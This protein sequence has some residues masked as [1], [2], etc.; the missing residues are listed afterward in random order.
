MAVQYC[1]YDIKG[2]LAVTGVSS[3]TGNATFA[4]GLAVNN[5]GSSRFSIT[6][7]VKV[8]GA[9]D[10]AIPAGRKFYLDGQSNTYLTES[11]ADNLKFFTGG[12]V[13]LLLNSSQN[14]IFANDIT[15]SGGDIVSNGNTVVS[16]SANANTLRL[17]DALLTSAVLNIK[18][19]TNG[20]DR[21]TI[22]SS[23][24]ATFAGN[25]SALVVTARDNLFVDAGQLYIG[26]DN[27]S[28]DN[29][30]RQVVNTGAGTFTL[31]KRISGTFTN[32]LSFDNSNN[33]TFAGHVFVEDGSKFF[34]A[35]AIAASSEDGNYVASFGKS[36]SGSAKF[37]GNIT[38]GGGTSTF[39][40]LVS[41]ITPTSG[42]NFA[43]KS[44]VDGLTP[45]SG[46]FLPLVGGTMSGA[47]NMG[48]NDIDGI[49]ELKFSSG[50]KLGDAGGTSYVSL[51]YADSGDGGILVI[52]NQGQHQ[53]YLYGDGGATSSFGLLDGTGSWAVRCL[54]DQYVELRY[55]NAIKLRTATGGINVTGAGNF[56]GNIVANDGVSGKITISP[57]N[58]Q[59]N[60]H[61]I[62]GASGGANIEMYTNGNAYYD[63]VSHNFRDSDA[64]PTYFNITAS[65]VN[66]FVSLAMNNYKI[67]TLA[68][69]TNAAD[70][71]N[72]AYVDAQI[73]TIPSGLNFQGNW[74]ASTNSP[75]LA[76]GTGTPGFYYNVSV[77][78]STNLDGETDWQVGD[79]AVFVENG[80]NDFWEKIDNTSA[81]TG[82]GAN[83]QVSLWGGTN[84]LEG[85]TALTFT[86]GDLYVTGD[87][88][89]S[90]WYSAYQDTITAFSDSGSSTI[91]L[92]LTQRDGGTLT[93]S[94]S[95][96]QGTVTGTGSVNVIPLW[97]G[98]GSLSTSYLQQNTSLANDILMPQYIRHT[99]DT[100]T[101]IGFP[102]GDRVILH[103]GGNSNVELVSNGVTL[104]NNGSTKLE[105]SSTGVS[106]TGEGVFTNTSSGAETDTI[107]LRN[108][109]T[110]QNTATALKFFP[111]TSTTRF[112]SIV[113]KNVTG[114]N[115]ISLSFLT[116]AGNTPA[117]ALTLDASQNAT[118]AGSV[119]VGGNAAS[120][121]YMV[122]ITP[123][124]GN[125]IRST[126]G[127]SV[128]GS[129]QSNNS[130]V[131]LG[132]IS[133][134]T[135]KIITNDTTAITV[136]N[137]QG[138]TFAGTIDSGAVTST[139]I[140]KSNTA[141]AQFKLT[142][143]HGRETVLG[144]GGGNFHI[145]PDHGSGVGISYGNTTYPGL[146][147]LYNNTTAK[148]TLDATAGNATFTGN[149]AVGNTSAAEIYLNRSSANY[150]NA[151][152][153]AGYLVFRTGGT[154]TALTLDASQDA[155]F[156][157][158]VNVGTFSDSGTSAINIRAGGEH[159]TKLGLFESNLNHGF[160][161]NY[162]G[163]LNQFLIK[164]HDNSAAGSTVLS[165][166]RVNN[167]AVFA[168]DI[169]VQGGDI[170]LGGTGRIQG[171]DTVSD[172]TDAANKAY[173]DAHV[174]PAGTYLPLAGG[175]M[176]DTNKIKFYNASQYI[177]ANSTNDLTIASGDDI[178][179][180]SNFSRFY[181]SGL[182]FARLS[183]SNDSWIANGTNSKLGVNKSS[184]INYNL[185]V[186]GT[187]RTTGAATIEG[188]I[189]ANGTIQTLAS[190]A[191]LTISG[192]SSGNVY[193][194]NT[195]GEHRWRANGSSVN[196]ITLSSSLLTVN[197]PAT[198][199]G[200][201]TTNLSSEGT[202]FT[203]GSGG[204]R[205]LSITS[206]TNSSAHALHTFNIASTNGKY[207]F[208]VNGTTEL[209]LD[210]SSA[211]FAGDIIF[212]NNNQALK[213]EGSDNLLVKVKAGNTVM[214]FDGGNIKTVANQN[215]EFDAGL[216]D[217][218]GSTG[219]AGQLLSSTGTTV[220]W[221][222]APSGGGANGTTAE[223]TGSN[224]NYFSKL[225]TFTIS[226]S[227]SFADL[228]AAFTII[229]EETSNSAYAEISVMMRKG[230]SSATSLDAINIAVLN[231]V[232]NGDIESQISSDNFYL[233]YTSGATM[234]VDLYMKKNA[235]FG[236]FDIIETASNFDDW[237]TTYYTNS[238]W[239]SALPSSTYT[240]QTKVTSGTF[241]TGAG[242]CRQETPFFGPQPTSPYP[243]WFPLPPNG[244]SNTV[245]KTSLQPTNFSLWQFQ[246]PV[247][248]VFQ[249][250][251]ISNISRSF[252]NM[253]VRIFDQGNGS[254]YPGTEVFTSATFSA[255][256]HVMAAVPINLIMDAGTVYA[257]SIDINSN[258]SP[259]DY[260]ITNLFAT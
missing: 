103:A 49:D 127:T 250:V 85:T 45:G 12:S 158:D 174:S 201:I 13:A 214:T 161:L 136:S 124:A 40:G 112:A 101:L 202:Y 224:A 143:T 160:S 71:A 62:L 173:V 135:F 11:S 244:P 184:G 83:N 134:N 235:T 199:T 59:S 190:N 129:Y 260:R 153:A 20:A 207:E 108:S 170:T 26:A 9:T 172:G 77:A 18:L 242:F 138:A 54:E 164:R 35:N 121:G 229:G 114:N 211:T 179:Y 67:T 23:G 90:N 168:G 175:T 195:A 234:A 162:D 243:N 48:D 2:T 105:T 253:R 239:I 10:F 192:D 203:G 156:A 68:T 84:T 151:S 241:I 43:T 221:I 237:V 93:T 91:T 193:Y 17:G 254:T 148:I 38:V 57:D 218:N 79:W 96:P 74:N 31:Q 152:N 140:I 104:R 99:G 7:D 111:T 169:S 46:V 106:V 92:T 42:A 22:N 194:N 137:S 185:D 213:V 223:G 144:Q 44:Y 251:S 6:G 139:G 30:F 163:G 238:A 47:I 119:G 187:F 257:M 206:G 183:G 98:T 149:L 165:L 113:A 245:A 186:E 167:G 116:A 27:G 72:K 226:S 142:S 51:T 166:N 210:S 94:F 131:Y 32:V 191:N 240:I 220:D 117:V 28:T 246:M 55:D 125:I 61:L 110:A 3:F 16:N 63:A 14:A 177:H 33:A 69:P 76:S 231:N 247:D 208:D 88:N 115:S 19:R 25:T 58:I 81:L 107:S 56:T 65:Q 259:N 205:Q 39:A 78:G 255:A 212:E 8:L 230:S 209:S 41:G 225:A 100:N 1:N 252:T 120:N 36:T 216:I 109:A 258:A 197:E 53:G 178:N 70:A 141:E 146:L 130:D 73:Q 196:S 64:S 4:N 180:L 147:K 132:T 176:T 89:S 171:I 75:T 21:L 249:Q 34:G 122:D 145:L 233:K 66:S 15:V 232:T 217:V 128:F 181:T 227:S 150:I 102:A 155:T 188:N 159:D 133:N 198:F 95:N 29:T 228:R 219:S 157:G 248:G 52:D 222:D 204:V 97:S 154:G 200:S 5:A 118:F 37:A 189:V 87:G 60:Q 82:V 24:N 236:Q 86:G 256:Q 123:T 215:F 182:E 126:R 80:A 50:T